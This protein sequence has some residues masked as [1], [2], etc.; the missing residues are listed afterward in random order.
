MLEQMYGCSLVTVDIDEM[1]QNS[2][3]KSC[4]R[5]TPAEMLLPAL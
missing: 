2:I 3:I 4:N 5:A 1:Q